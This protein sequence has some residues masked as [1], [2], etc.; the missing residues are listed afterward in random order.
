MSVT[1]YV[2]QA[3][4]SLAVLMLRLFWSS[5]FWSS[6][7]VRRLVARFHYAASYL[8]PS[9]TISS[10]K[11][12]YETIRF[13]PFVE[14]FSV[15][16]LYSEFLKRREGVDFGPKPNCQLRSVSIV[17]TSFRLKTVL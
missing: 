4:L 16:L 5:L 9:Y 3:L 14:C 7:V 1:L 13:T 8:Q 12:S 11:A 10:D 15:I 6:L 2:L 17:V